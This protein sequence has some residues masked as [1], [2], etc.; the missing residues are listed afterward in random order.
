MRRIESYPPHPSLHALELPP[1]EQ[2]HASAVAFL[3]EGGD[4]EA[5]SLLLACALSTWPVGQDWIEEA[6]QVGLHVELVGPREAYD[7]LCDGGHPI[8]MAI[9]EAVAA[10]LPGYLYLDEL[11]ARAEMVD[12]DPGW[13][14]KLLEAARG[15]G[16]HNQAGG[17]G[18][19]HMWHGLRFRSH[20]EVTIAKALDRAGVMYLA[21]CLARLGPPPHRFTREADF[22]VCCDG[23]WGI[24]EVDGEPFHPASR[25][26]EDHERD[27]S[28]RLQGVP[29]VEHFDA[30]ECRRDPDGVVR[31]FLKVLGRA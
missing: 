10:T 18:A 15:D 2:I 13:R 29:V 12:V 19:A 6:V 21:N 4:K 3:L 31:R 17:N 27:R 23:R 30:G 16:V 11:S 7:T 5:A 8:A 25:A 24:L 22:L 14:G 26:A 1:A 28:F 20:S 9:R